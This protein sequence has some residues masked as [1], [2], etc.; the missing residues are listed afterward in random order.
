MK[1]LLFLC[2]V[3]AGCASNAMKEPANTAD[4]DL[5]P[6]I[7]SRLVPGT[8]LGNVALQRDT[9]AKITESVASATEHSDCAPPQMT[10][11]DTWTYGYPIQ[12]TYDD[13]F[14]KWEEQ[15]TLDACGKDVDVELAYM[16]H[17]SG[18]VYLS[19]KR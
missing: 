2:C 4:R 8:T 3:L 9:I 12:S 6:G 11:I 19:I 17:K 5:K 18:L 15:W 16:L 10:V 13:A 14:K 1:A 7:Q